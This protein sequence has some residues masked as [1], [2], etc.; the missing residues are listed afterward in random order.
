MRNEMAAVRDLATA[1]LSDRPS[2]EDLA[3]ATGIVARATGVAEAMIVYARDD[4]FLSSH[5]GS[6]RRLRDISEQ[7]LLVIQRN[8]TRM[9][10][11]LAFDLSAGRVEA[12]RNA[13]GNTSGEFLAFH[14]PT[15]EGSSEMCLLRTAGPKRIGR[16][17]PRLMESAAPA[18]TLLL[19]RLL[20][21]E[22]S[23]RQKGQLEA[24]GSAAQ[25]LTRAKDM[26]AALTDQASSIASATGFDFVSIDV[27]DAAAGRFA[28]LAQVWLDVFD[29]DHPDELASS[30]LASGEPRLIVDLQHD[31]KLSEGLRAFFKQ[32]LLTS[33]AVL[34][35]TFQDELLGTIAFV[36]Y[37]P[38][39]FAPE[40]VESME[41]LANQMATALKA[42][43]MYDEL[44]RAREETQQYAGRIER[45]QGKLRKQAAKLRQL[46][47]TDALTGLCNYA[48]WHATL[49]RRLT[50]ARTTGKPLSVIVADVDDFKLFNDTYGHL[51][52]D[53]ALRVISSAIGSACRR[54]DV[55]GRCGGDEF[56]IIL[57][58]TERQAA[59]RVAKARATEAIPLRL[60][61]GIAAFPEDGMTKDGLIGYADAAMYDSK[62]LP[63]ADVAS[64]GGEE[65]PDQVGYPNSAFGLLD[66]LVRSID[67][68]DHY[69]RAHSENEAQYAVLMGE[70]LGLSDESLRALRIAGLLHDV[71]KVGIP[72]RILRKPGRLTEDERETMQ[73]HVLITERIV[74]GVPHLEDVL[75]AASSHHERFDGTGYPRGLRGEDIPILGRLLAVADAFSAMTEDRPY[76]KALPLSAAIR[77]L[78]DCAGTQFDPDLV[79]I[80]IS[81]VLPHIE[82]RPARAA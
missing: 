72:D 63:P 9:G 77:E 43:R 56:M 41:S 17:L 49:E 6:E 66:G 19:E 26:K 51:A 67:R 54:T 44:A 2:T 81:N 55:I 20:N 59:S 29:P 73:R 8:L 64:V 28:S 25:V 70:A 12:F 23:R 10:S 3:Q 42:M 24:I 40:E 58:N 37:K 32:S 39:T 1:A 45:Q 76:R 48:R 15:T 80:F 13:T 35:M 60:A 74:A 21:A 47:S 52:G 62:T 65:S 14:V 7:A 18:L 78:R 27:Y 31:E 16:R 30:I 38:R 46:A 68:R 71:G 33:G 4:E 57:P 5:D 50:R 34:P 75:S 61:I 69:T 53:E 36:S 79:E 11:P 22:R 82:Q